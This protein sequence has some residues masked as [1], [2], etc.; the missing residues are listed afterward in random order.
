[1][2]IQRGYCALSTAACGPQV[3]EP[4]ATDTASMHLASFY[5]YNKEREHA[6]G[7]IERV[8]R[9]QPDYM[10]ASVSGGGD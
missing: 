2:L 4:S 8:Q 5:L 7:L 6:R 1:M 9:N 3:E 10:P